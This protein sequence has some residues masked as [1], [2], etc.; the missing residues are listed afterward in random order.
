MKTI[1][2]F[3]I[4]GNLTGVQ[5]V[6]IDADTK[7]VIASHFCSSVNFAKSD[8][9]FSTPIFKTCF[10]NDEPHSTVQFNSDRHK[11]Y[12][13]LYPEGYELIWSDTPKEFVLC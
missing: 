3:I 2:G 9:G 13:E 11:K 8:L 10:S 7:E 4:S 5:A 6:V 1:Y 12:T